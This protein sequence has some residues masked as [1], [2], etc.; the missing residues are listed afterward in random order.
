[1]PQYSSMPPQIDEERT[2]A[3]LA[4]YHVPEL[5][6]CFGEDKRKRYH[7]SLKPVL[8]DLIF[9]PSNLAGAIHRFP[10]DIVYV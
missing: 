1:M 5:L 7:G 8:L 10:K 6:E 3:K 2:R 4:R 9:V